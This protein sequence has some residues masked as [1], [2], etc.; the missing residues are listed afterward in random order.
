MRRAQGD[1]GATAVLVL[2]VA[3]LLALT[4][5]VTAA[6][7]AVGVA[8]QRAAAVADLAALAG[9]Q[10]AL[11]GR[12]A[13][14]RGAARVA[15]DGAASLQSCRVDGDVV[16]VVAVVRPPGPLGRLGASTGRARAGPA[17]LAA[18]GTP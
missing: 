11:D 13:A 1:R 6:T 17:G 18:A 16:E 7:A 3:G 12:T 14:C 10:H 4:G 2:A 9:A 15:A 5:A 8:R